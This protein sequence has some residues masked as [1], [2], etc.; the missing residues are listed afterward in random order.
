MSRQGVLAEWAVLSEPV[1]R[2]VCPEFPEDR[3]NTGNS[4]KF[5]PHAASSS[6]GKRPEFVWFWPEFSAGPNRE[7][8]GQEQRK[9]CREQGRWRVPIGFAGL[10]ARVTRNRVLGSR[11]PA[12]ICDFVQIVFAHCPRN[13]V[14]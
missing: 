9:G 5:R 11:A 4:F 12:S 7:F 2:R 1:S 10:S 13:L 3:E 6:S 8:S 14:T